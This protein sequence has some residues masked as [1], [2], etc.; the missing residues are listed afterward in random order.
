MSDAERRWNKKAIQVKTIPT[1]VPA[2]K[3]GTFTIGGHLPVHRL[4]FGTVRL[5]CHEIPGSRPVKPM[6]K[7]YKAN[8]D[9]AKLVFSAV[10]HFRG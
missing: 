6:R 7:L 1:N 3:S 4:G 5:R 8:D 10:A 9:K 2:G